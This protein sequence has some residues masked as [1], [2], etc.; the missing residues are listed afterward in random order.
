MIS[1]EFLAEISLISTL[2]APEDLILRDSV[3]MPFSQVKL[4]DPDNST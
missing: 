4:P 3:L 1:I 2:P